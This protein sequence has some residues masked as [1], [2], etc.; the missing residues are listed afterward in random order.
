MQTNDYQLENNIYCNNHYAEKKEVSLFGT[1]VNLFNNQFQES[2]KTIFAFN[3][4][5]KYLWSF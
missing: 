3:N 4:L 1:D 5:E 2:L